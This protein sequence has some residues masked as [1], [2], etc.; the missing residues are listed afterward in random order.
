MLSGFNRRLLNFLMSWWFFDEAKNSD[1]N[2]WELRN[3][4][5]QSWS[6][7]EAKMNYVGKITNFL[8]KWVKEMK[9]DI[10]KL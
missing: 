1:T 9:N 8:E 10:K 7:Y 6:V 2:K 3:K 4:T 5:Y